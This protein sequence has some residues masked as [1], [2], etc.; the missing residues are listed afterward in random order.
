MPNI[1][2]LPS[3]SRRPRGTPVMRTLVR[4]THICVAQLG[5]RLDRA[6]PAWIAVLALTIGLGLAVTEARFAPLSISY[7]VATWLFYYGGIALTLGTRLNVA[8]IARLGPEAAFRRYEVLVGTMFASQGLGV[9]AMCALDTGA[10]A[11]PIPPTIAIPVGALLFVVGFGT[12]IWAIHLVGLDTLYFKDLF[13]G[14]TLGP[15]VSR[16]PYRLFANPI[17]GVGQIHGYG[18][19]LAA[20]SLTGLVATAI[21]QLS[22]Y[23]FYFVVER[24]FIARLYLA[25]AS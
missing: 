20:G 22:I 9:G 4:L 18:L 3:R 6:R 10:W 15:F 19:A 23:A 8:A 24:P 11:L 14:R 2:D 7:F 1:S 25:P 5:L 16:G 17:Y 12:K 13:L 21:C